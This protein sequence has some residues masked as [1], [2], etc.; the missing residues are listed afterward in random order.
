[1]HDKVNDIE[2]LYLRKDRLEREL[3]ALNIQLER[4][5]S[6]FKLYISKDW[7]ADEIEAAKERAEKQF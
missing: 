2:I 4:E 1:M 6:D 5:E 7:T 3:T